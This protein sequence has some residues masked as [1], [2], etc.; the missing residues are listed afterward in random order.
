M[1][2]MLLILSVLILFTG[3]AIGQ[4]SVIPGE[5][6]LS[7]ALATAVDGDVLQLVPGGLYTES[8]AFEFG[9]F[10][11]R[12]ITIE[13]EDASLDKPKIWLTTEPSD[14]SSAVFFEMGD[15]SSLTL[16]GLEL[17]G[18]ET[19]TYL[20]SF[21]LGDTQADMVINKI[22][23]T[24]CYIHDINEDVVAAGS[25]SIRGYTVIDS[26]IIDDVI[27]ENTGTAIYYKYAG[28]N[29]ISV[30]NSTFNTI[31]SYGMRIS[32]PV[33]N[34]KPDNTPVVIVDHTTWYNIGTVDG[35]E[36]LLAEKG[37]NLNPWTVSNSIF[38]KHVPLNK[39]F[40]NIKETPQSTISNIVFWETN[41]ESWTNSQGIDHIV[42]DTLRADP[43]FVEPDSGD[44]TLAIGS[45]A[46][47]W[48]EGYLPVGDPRWATN[49]TTSVDGNHQLPQS[50]SLEQN[51]PN[52]FNPTTR[53]V[54]NLESAAQTQLN[55]YDLN[56]KLVR[57]LINTHLTPGEHELEFNAADISS[58]LYM[59]I[60][61]SGGSSIARK[62]MVLK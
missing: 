56:G 14:E 13:T 50:M 53:I 27:V 18:L 62:M 46:L 29:F 45:P 8:T 32:G 38:V 24:D 1:K 21:T 60:L 28:S 4:T 54:F 55:I 44:F 39:S 25:S 9:T 43:L 7:A 40:I 12:A 34:L 15:N 5:G 30:T 35:R 10:T 11:N 47:F 22:K 52:P 26:T 3:L 49:W 42:V 37:P 19:A 48:G 57:S 33:E 17:D 2:R 58:G 51:Y 23:I 36:I 16:N 6:T 41:Q 31:N 61:E 59:Y 20:I